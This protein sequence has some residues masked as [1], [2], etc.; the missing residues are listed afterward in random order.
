M[1]NSVFEEFKFFIKKSKS[2]QY[3]G[4]E[5]PNAELFLPLFKNV[6]HKLKILSL[7]ESTEEFLS[8]KNVT[9]YFPNLEILRFETRV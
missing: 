5:K 2:L 3:L 9:K 4:I 7:R 8:N 1:K 6:G